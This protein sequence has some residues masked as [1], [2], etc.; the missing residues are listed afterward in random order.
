MN[1]PVF[2]RVVVVVINR[3]HFSNALGAASSGTRS[4]KS[5]YTRDEGILAA[6][7][8]RD[9]CWSSVV[10]ERART[11]REARPSGNRLLC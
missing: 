3:F 1:E 10:P 5:I 2:S 8:E 7:P 9:D 6:A 11:P 4:E